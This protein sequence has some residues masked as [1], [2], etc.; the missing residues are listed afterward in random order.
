MPRNKIFFYIFFV[1]ALTI[2]FISVYFHSLAYVLSFITICYFFKGKFRVFLLISLCLLYIN[3]NYLT[4][5]LDKK[6]NKRDFTY[7][8]F[9]KSF[10]SKNEYEVGELVIGK[11]SF[12][13][14]YY[15]IKVFPVFSVKIPFVSKI[16]EFRRDLS[17]KFNL[18]SGGRLSIVQGLVLGDKKFIDNSVK[19][20]FTF[21]GINHYLAISGMHVGIITVILIMLIP[22]IHLKLK[23]MIVGAFLFIF[24]ALS[25]FK[26]PVLRSVIFF[27]VLTF[28]YIMEIK[29]RFKEFVIFIAS[30]FILLSPDVVT[31]LSFI[32]SFAAMSG[33]AF[34]VDTKKD[35]ITNMLKTSVA[36]TVFTLPFVLYFFKMFNILSIFNTLIL[37]P[38][39]YLHIATGIFGI[40]FTGLSIAPLTFSESMMLKVI[41]FLVS[42]E[43]KFFITNY[44]PTSVFIILLLILFTSL[45]FNK[46]YLLFI[47]FILCVIPYKKA[48]DK[49][50]FPNFIR[51]KAIVDLN[52][53]REVYYQG[54]YADFRYKFLPFLAEQGIGFHFDRGNI[55]IYDGENIFLTVENEENKLSDVCINNV[56]TSCKIV[57]FTNKNSFTLSKY[58]PDK[59]YVI[60][61]TNYNYDNI[62]KL[63]NKEFIAI[64]KEGVVIE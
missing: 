49:I 38:F 43:K 18:K 56:Q 21:L 51:S 22:K 32:L 19:D 46:K 9:S 26:I 6:A 40:F 36:A 8:S 29:V 17:E 16:L 1:I 35:F 57:Y 58:F 33:I 34:L 15:R 55:K 39:I 4:L 20:K 25:G 47:L 48:D 27:F 30:L 5:I 31:N 54:F 24:L 2:G 45:I 60:Y 64:T 23:L 7:Y 11:K 37:F 13:K 61:D 63:K 42:V 50:F 14:N 59:L 62:F 41:D 53:K 12:E 10:K 28:A 3:H 52:E 44:I